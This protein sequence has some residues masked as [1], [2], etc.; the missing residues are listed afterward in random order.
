MKFFCDL[1]THSVFS[2]GT[3]TPTQIVEEAE[4]LGLAAVALTDHNTVAGLS[5]FTRAAEG[6]DI[7]AIGGIEFSTDF[8]G[9]ELHI[10]GLF[11]QPE[12]YDAIEEFI[13]KTVQQKEESNIRLADTLRQNGYAIDYDILKSKYP[14]GRLNRAHIAA[15]LTELGYTK[16]IQ[17]AFET[18]L[19]EDKGFY[20]PPTHLDA[21]ETI[22]FIRSIH[23]VSVL[24]HPMIDMTEHQLHTFLQTT[25]PHGLCAMETIYPLYNAQNMLR[26]SGFAREYGI[27]PSGG[28]DFHGSNKPDIRLGCGKGNV[29]VPYT[30]LAE[31]KKAVT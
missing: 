21:V 1:H 9:L 8:N 30:I 15:F 18:V 17:E 14:D 24:A 31:L 3:C 2:D 6:K 7:E 29:A 5:E 13:K 19:S 11:I 27:L 25:V 4:A 16:S 23:A 20:V 10:L 28:S 22:G 12:Y 26:A